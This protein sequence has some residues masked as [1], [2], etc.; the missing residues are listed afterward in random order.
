MVGQMVGCIVLGV[1]LERLSPYHFA[2]IAKGRVGWGEKF[3]KTVAG[4]ECGGENSEEEEVIV[5]VGL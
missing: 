1:R 3:T 5:V 2:P 4:K